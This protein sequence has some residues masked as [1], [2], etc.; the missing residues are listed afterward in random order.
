[1]RVLI[2]GATGFIGFHAA[3][4]LLQAGHA[5]RALVRDPER[6]ARVLQP[7]DVAPEA[8]V[9]GDMT[10][11][12]RV[13]V[14]VESCDAVVHAAAGVSVTTS[15]SRFDTNVEGTKRV[16]GAAIERSLPCVYLSSLEAI[17]V[18]RGE[19]NEASPVV[20]GQGAYSRSKAAA[21]HWVRERCAEGAAI[22]TVYP[23]GVVGP[24]DPGMSESVRAYRGFLRGTLRTG[25]THMADA[26]DLG[27]LITRLLETGR[28]GRIIAS[29]HHLRWTEMNALLARVAGRPVPELKAPGWAL[30]GAGRLCDGISRLSGRKMPFTAESMEIATRW[31]RVENSP[32]IAELGIAWR[33]AE[34]TLTDMFRWFLETGRLPAKAVPALAP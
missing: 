5:V 33:P 7:I 2:T 14:A 17:M 13:A 8:L 15:A 1:M 9:V 4:A 18:R 12:S 29:G 16:V 31:V 30:R 3:R 23:A 32:A 28:S 6:A 20:A 22:A 11:P 19:V 21:E 34:E 10:D 24:D 27:L 26:R 25:S